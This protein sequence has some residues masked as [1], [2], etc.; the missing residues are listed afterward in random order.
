[1][2]SL[3]QM[4]NELLGYRVRAAETPMWGTGDTLDEYARLAINDAIV[5]YPARIE[6]TYTSGVCENGVVV[7]PNCIEHVIRIEVCATTGV[8]RY[9]AKHWHVVPTPSTVY[10]QIHDDVDGRLDVTYR[11]LQSELPADIN[12]VVDSLTTISASAGRTA[13]NIWPSMG[14]VELSAANASLGDRREIVRYG[15]TWCSGAGGG[16][17]GGFATL[18]RGVEGSDYVAFDGGDVLSAC[19]VCADADLRPVMLQAQASMFGF[20]LRH[21]AAYEA[22][23]ARTSEMVLNIEALQVLIQS[24]EGRARRARRLQ[25]RLPAPVGA[26][27]RKPIP[28]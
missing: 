8:E 16:T 7:L 22:Y 17:E 21:R 4:T 28:S 24:L 5:A 26:Q 19:Y 18:T 15:T 9:E 20:W 23:A 6:V 12:I 2:K 1:M 13:V 11:Y 27:R 10:V 25:R 3:R 14:Y